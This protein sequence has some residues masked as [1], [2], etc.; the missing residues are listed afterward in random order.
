MDNTIL[1][2]AMAGGTPQSARYGPDG[3]TYR[4]AR[5]NVR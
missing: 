4:I 1:S 3:A 2:T 5:R